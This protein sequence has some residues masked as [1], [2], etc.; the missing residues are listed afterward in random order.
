LPDDYVLKAAGAVA[1]FRSVAAFQKSSVKILEM[2]FQWEEWGSYSEENNACPLY[3]PQSL[4]IQK[5]LMLS[6]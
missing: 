2:R 1:V 6:S 4:Q 3:H 5:H